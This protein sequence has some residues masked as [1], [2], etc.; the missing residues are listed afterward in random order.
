MCVVDGGNTSD[1]VRHKGSV[2]RMRAE[3]AR[4]IYSVVYIFYKLYCSY[5]LNM[6][7][8]SSLFSNRCLS[9]SGVLLSISSNID[10]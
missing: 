6:D 3:R 4:F 2:V 7:L 5:L 1:R 10:E 8:T 9:E